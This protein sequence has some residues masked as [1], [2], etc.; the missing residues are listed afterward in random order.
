MLYGAASGS[1][2]RCG[3]AAGVPAHEPALVDHQSYYAGI[4]RHP[5]SESQPADRAPAPGG[6]AIVQAFLNTWD[7]ER[8]VDEL[9][10]PAH[11]RSWLTERGLG[12]RPL[13]VSDQD[14]ADALAL[15]EAL[16]ALAKANN[17]MAF[18]PDTVRTLNRIE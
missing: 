1:T 3:G 18:D 12:E 15:R 13:P 6:L 10:K 14:L 2:R 8:G 11:L 17:G 9:T 4:L 16:R 7:I 5:S